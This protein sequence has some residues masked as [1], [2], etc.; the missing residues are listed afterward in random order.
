MSVHVNS[1]AT[2][3]HQ[4]ATLASTVERFRQLFNTLSAGNVENLDEVY[5]PGIRFA[6][7]FGSV[8]G[9]YDLQEYFTKVYANVH[10]CRFEFSETIVSGN[11]ACLAWVMYL[12]HPRLRRGREVTVA[13]MSHLIVEEGRVQSHRDYFDAGAL[14]YENLPLLGSA[15]RWIR[16]YAS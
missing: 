14:L 10:S 7:P 16:N 12:K 13:G 5:S 1:S 8:D 2:S 15:I 4:E 3:L 9:I 11:Q 6:D